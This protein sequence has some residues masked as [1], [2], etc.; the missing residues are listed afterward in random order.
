VIA[1]DQIM[2]ALQQLAAISETVSVL[3]DEALEYRLST[4][5]LIDEVR[6]EAR[7]S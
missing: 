2:Y 1:R 3:T 7:R 5:T 6:S 4:A